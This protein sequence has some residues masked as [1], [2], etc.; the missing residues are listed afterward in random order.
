[1]SPRLMLAAG[2]GKHGRW[3]IT[4]DQMVQPIHL[5][6]STVIGLPT[7]LWIPSTPEIAPSSV[8]QVGFKYSHNLT[9][10]WQFDVELYHRDLRH[11]IDYT[12]SGQ[13]NSWVDNL[14]VGKGFANGVEL[15]AHYSGRKLKGWINYT[16]AESR[17]QFDEEINRGRPFPFQFD[18]RH[19]V[20]LFAT[21]DVSPA[22]NFT[23][24]WRYGSGAFYSL[25]LENFLLA[26]PSIL[27]DGSAQTVP[28]VE[29][30]NGFNLPSNHR[31]DVNAQ[32]VF[33]GQET[34]RFQ[35]LLN[36]GVYNLYS[37]HNPIFYDLRTNFFSR[38][39]ELF[40]DQQFVQGF[41]GGIQPTLSYQLS[42]S[43]KR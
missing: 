15:S 14:S 22:V 17:R 33:R 7:D 29:N 2:L 38:G 10:K 4:Y 19:G 11:L 37:R 42:F 20:K 25:S 8:R 39:S 12:E 43:G 3:R 16:L 9:T 27:S 18:R 30:K 41:F 23:A 6:S 13:N 35:H 26:D 32:F 5:V 24:T 31:L 36:I 28:L 21:Y 34:K 1:M 40:K